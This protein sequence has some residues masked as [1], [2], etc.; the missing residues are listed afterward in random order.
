MRIVKRTLLFLTVALLFAACVRQTGIPPEIS[1]LHELPSKPY[2]LTKPELIIVDAGHGGKDAGASSKKNHYEEKK[3]TLET[4]FLVVEQLKKLGYRT[5]LTRR[6]D[7]FVPL[8]A[9]A[10]IANE[11]EGDLFVSIH[12]NYC[13]DQEVEGIEVFYYKE[14]KKPPSQR[15]AQSKQLGQE[16]LRKIV[17][18]G[19]ESRGVKEGN[20]AVVRETKMPA[21]LIEAGFLSNPQELERIKDGN[22]L[23]SLSQA[24]AQGIDNYLLL[25]RH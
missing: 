22:Y 2:T 1:I 12:Y 3:L 15:I 17:K 5:T 18:A 19:A 7:I 23:H 10:E 21:I 20:F 16:V 6:D 24:I 25:K 14:N 9:R 13:P 8:A 11:A 4:A